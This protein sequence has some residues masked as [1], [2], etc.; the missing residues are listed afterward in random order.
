M[1]CQ[2]PIQVT[3][4]PVK[5]HI[6]HTINVYSHNKLIASCVNLN[7][8]CL[9]L[10]QCQGTQHWRPVP[11]AGLSGAT[12]KDQQGREPRITVQGSPPT[13]LKLHQ[14]P[15]HWGLASNAILP[16]AFKRMFDGIWKVLSQ[17][18]KKK[19][20]TRPAI[21]DLECQVQQHAQFWG[22]DKLIRSHH[23]VES[24]STRSLDVKEN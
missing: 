14:R 21:P 7:V 15:W 8:A 1:N 19:K 3:R 22:T 9:S 6:Y 18:Q 4:T 10:K 11:N 16:N 17:T 24:V 12:S 23:T 2:W 20:I 5:H 13:I